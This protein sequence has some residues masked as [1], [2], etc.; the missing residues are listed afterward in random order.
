MRQA[1][2]IHERRTSADIV[3][4]YLYEEIASLRLLPGSKIS[5]AEIATQLGVS[6]Q[7][8]RDAFNRLSNIDMLV[9]KPQKATEVKKFSLSSIE[10]ARFSRLAIELE[11]LSIAAQNWD[12]TL[13]PA[14][15]ENLVAQDVAVETLD[16]A[17]FHQLDYDFHMLICRV[18]KREFASDIIA[19]ARTEIDRLCV[20]SLK[21][22]ASMRDV[23]QDHANLVTL[24]EQGDKSGLI[25]AMR[26]HL[27]R[28]DATI[29]E[30]YGNSREYFQD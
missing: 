8:V 19:N 3:F 18:A 1:I 24:F 10:S 7:P 28:L 27:G 2:A 14:F 22:Q 6:R 20:L 30:I 13:L 26:Q 11:V 16:G 23:V 9:V 4:D 12:G 15:R 17:V 5:E 25:K 21:T 29:E